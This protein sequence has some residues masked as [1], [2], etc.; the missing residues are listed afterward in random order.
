VTGFGRSALATGA[1]QFPR[2]RLLTSQP[3]VMANPQSTWLRRFGLDI[4][5]RTT[6]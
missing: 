3:A 5:R 6:W 4:H 1:L 2:Y